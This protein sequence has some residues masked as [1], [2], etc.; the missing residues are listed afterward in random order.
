MCAWVL[1][2]VQRINNLR[3]AAKKGSVSTDTLAD[4]ADASETGTGTSS[5]GGQQ[6]GDSHRDKERDVMDN[7]MDLNTETEVIKIH[8]EQL[9]K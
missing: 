5:Q 4:S 7:D 8:M 3:R 1:C 9:K 6:G 2:N